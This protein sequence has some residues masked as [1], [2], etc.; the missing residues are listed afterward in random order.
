MIL[1]FFFIIFAIAGL[2]LFSGLLKRRCFAPVT[3]IPHPEDLLC[4]SQSCPAGYIC[5][6]MLNNPNY[7]GHELRYDTLL[8]SA[9]FPVSHSRRMDRHHEV[10]SDHF[11]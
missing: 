6:K 2:Q 5:G 11:L 4:G 9:S 7:G 1:M 3:G 8:L 10:S